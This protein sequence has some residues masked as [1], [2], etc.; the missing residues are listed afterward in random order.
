MSCSVLQDEPLGLSDVHKEYLDLKRVFSK[1]IA[2]S[3]T[4]HCPYDCAI[5]LFPRMSSPKGRLYLLSTS[6]REDMEK[7]ISDS[8][9]AKLICPSSSPADLGFF[10]GE[11]M[12]GS[13][14]P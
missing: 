13:L 11:K 9:V 8:L 5:V 3:L 10:F 1:S 12:V 6:E 7:Y 14:R 2:A 4:P